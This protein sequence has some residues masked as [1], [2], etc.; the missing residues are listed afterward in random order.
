MDIQ[1]SNNAHEQGESQAY[2]VIL[3]CVTTAKKKNRYFRYSELR[4]SVLLLLFTLSI[5]T[6][7]LSYCTVLGT[8]LRSGTNIV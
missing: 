7:V 2:E 5:I 4:R 3:D 8:G 6:V 1:C